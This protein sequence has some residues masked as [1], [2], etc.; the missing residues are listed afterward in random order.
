MESLAHE[1]GQRVLPHFASYNATEI[2]AS[3]DAAL[4]Y[5]Q[6]Q[7]DNGSISSGDNSHLHSG[8]ETALRSPQPRDSSAPAQQHHHHHQQQHRHFLQSDDSLPRP[9]P[10]KPAPLRGFDAS[11]SYDARRTPPEEALLHTSIHHHF[12]VQRQVERDREIREMRES[13]D[14]R[15]LPL[16]LSHSRHPLP[17][18]HPPPLIS[19]SPAPR[20]RSP[21]LGHV[22]LGVP[23]GH[24]SSSPSSHHSQGQPIPS[25][26]AA[27]LAH[28]SSSSSTL[29]S[30]L[31][32]ASSPISRENPEERSLYRG[33]PWQSL[34]L[35]P[36]PHHPHHHHHH[37]LR[38]PSASYRDREP[39][40]LPSPSSPLRAASR[41]SGSVSDTGRDRGRETSSVYS[42]N[43]EIRV[44]SPR[45]RSASP[46]NFLHLPPK[47]RRHS[48][49]SD[50]SPD[51]RDDV[52][53]PPLSPMNLTKTPSVFSPDPLESKNISSIS[54]SSNNSNNINNSSSNGHSSRPPSRSASLSTARPL[55]PSMKQS[56][57]SSTSSAGSP[58]PQPP[59]SSSDSYPS[60]S[61]VSRRSPSPTLMTKPSSTHR[62][63]STSSATST[64]SSKQ[65]PIPSPISLGVPPLAGLG[66]L[67]S[68][69]LTP[70]S[71]HSQLSAGLSPSSKA[72]QQHPTPLSAAFHGLH[73]PLFLPSPMH[74]VH[75]W[76]SLSPVATHSPRLN[77]GTAF[78]F[79]A[80]LNGP[81]AFSPLLGSFSASSVASSTA[82]SL[83]NL[84]TPGLVSTPTRTIPVL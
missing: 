15:R 28:S 53:S 65:K 33:A 27:P 20:A 46:I 71:S 59:V 41:G 44:C 7:A 2:K 63:L 24:H 84:G 43:P 25:L 80:F 48:R 78:Q 35:S 10:T 66:G 11:P 73:T 14:A 34:Y 18:G 16:H 51:P 58:S 68:A 62:S 26:P 3:Q 76:S 4:K 38:H 81:L 45:G 1:Y 54:S 23:G 9:T 56:V 49:R 77:S 55:S 52:N 50:Y 19:E 37:H 74:P 29:S 47:A 42:S 60:T 13:L 21:H 64:S 69:P 79:P 75:F 12:L 32:S 6:L 5:S 17:H 22:H 30:S 70:I 61:R 31:S 57:T 72:P 36:D 82:A 67:G 39:H 40:S 83:E 8:G